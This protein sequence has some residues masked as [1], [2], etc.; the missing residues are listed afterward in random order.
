M[1]PGR[2]VKSAWDPVEAAE[3]QTAG[4]LLKAHK[5]HHLTV[6]IASKKLLKFFRQVKARS[7]LGLN[8]GLPPNSDIPSTAKMNQK[9]SRSSIMSLMALKLCETAAARC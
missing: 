7:L 5:P 6:H 3:P 8:Q 4:I 1:K 9:S 2:S